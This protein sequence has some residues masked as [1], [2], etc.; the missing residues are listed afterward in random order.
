M[1]M[2]FHVAVTETVSSCAIILA[3]VCLCGF[4]G[5]HENNIKAHKHII[6]HISTCN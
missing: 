1:H 6:Y 4:A 5:E 2:Y 3:Q